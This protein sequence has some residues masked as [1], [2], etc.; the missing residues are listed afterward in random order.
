M[1]PTVTKLK[2]DNNGINCASI[3]RWIANR[4]RYNGIIGV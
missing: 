2:N 4:Y 3:P 1:K